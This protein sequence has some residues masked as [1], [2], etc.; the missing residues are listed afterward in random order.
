MAKIEDL[1]EHSGEDD[2]A[3]CRAF[4]L[5]YDVVIPAL[6]AWETQH[7]LKEGQLGL[8]TVLTAASALLE[9]DLADRGGLEAAL[10]EHLDE[11]AAGLLKRPT[12]P[13]S[14]SLQ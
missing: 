14:E 4:D 2:C 8:A 6:A 9:A 13:G 5:A 10:A 7:G 11:A 1:L 3:V 12:A